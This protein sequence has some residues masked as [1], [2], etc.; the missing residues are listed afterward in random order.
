VTKCVTKRFITVVQGKSVEGL[1]GKAFP[2]VPVLYFPRGTGSA[3]RGARAGERKRERSDNG[4][5]LYG[6]ICCR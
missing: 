4:D 5:P 2:R 3:G 1:M 6:I